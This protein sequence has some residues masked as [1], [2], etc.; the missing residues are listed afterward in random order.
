MSQ[1]VDI[2]PFKAGEP[3]LKQLTAARLNAMIDAI[4]RNGVQFGDNITGQRT[5]GGTIIRAKFNPSGAGE[6]PDITFFLS[7]ASTSEGDPPVV[8]NKVFVADGKIS[9]AFPSGMGT[10]EYIIDLADPSDSI[11]YAGITFNPTTLSIDSRFLGAA[12][13]GDFPLSRIDD[14]THGFAY[15]QLGFTF[16]DVDDVFRI[17]MSRVGDIEVI[18]SYGAVSGLP[19]LIVFPDIGGLALP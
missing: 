13:S 14:T 18:F 6:D 15:W 3:L 10:S 7:D 16:F 1:S 11:I 5:P 12:S 9:G 8:T 4:K 2:P 17:V 19:A